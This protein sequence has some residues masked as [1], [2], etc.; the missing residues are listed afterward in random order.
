MTAANKGYR[1]RTPALRLDNRDAGRRRFGIS[2]PV[3]ESQLVPLPLLVL[4]MCA[5]EAL[6]GGALEI[7]SSGS[8]PRVIGLRCAR[9]ELELLPE[10]GPAKQAVVARLE[11]IP[12]VRASWPWP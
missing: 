10:L 11:K 7:E 2:R 5:H 3:A 9:P 4:G 6:G 8:D 1:D 12:E